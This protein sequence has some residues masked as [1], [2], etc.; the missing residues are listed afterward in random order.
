MAQDVCLLIPLSL[1]ERVTAADLVVEGK[2]TSQ[3]SFWDD[4]HHNIYTA[5]QVE[6]FKVFK[7]SPSSNTVEIV[8]EGGRV[9][10]DIHVYSATL[11]LK[12]QEQGVFFLKSPA[13]KA[14]KARYSV[15]GSMQGFIKYKL[16]QGTAKDPF[17]EYSS[18]PLQ[19]HG[20]LARIAGISLRTIKANPELENALKAKPT[21]Q[22][23]RRLIPAITT[24]SPTS[25]RAGVGDVLTINGT[26]FG[27]TR[28]NGYVEFRN[29]DD[30]G[31]TF[32]KPL[33]SD[34]VS[35]SDTQI[36]VKV[37]TYG[38]DGGTAG[39][40]VF[41]VVNNDPN[42]A[43]SAT[44]VTIV[45]AY[46]NVGYEDE[47]RNIPLQSYQPRL[48]SQ[49][50][51]G[52]YTFRFGASFESNTPALYAFKRA[53]NEWSCTTFVNWVAASNVPVAST[54]DDE[55]N[56]IRFA[57]NG[58]LPANVLGRTISRYEGCIIGGT[59]VNFWV[60]EIDMEY[61]PNFNWQFGPD[62]P[63]NQQFDFQ[64]VVV[65]ELGH[66][67]QLSHLILPRAVMHY[68]VGRG[69]SSRT[70][71]PT[72]DIAGGNYVIT[73]SLVPFACDVDLMEPKSPDACAIPIELI[74]LEGELL[75]DN[76][77]RLEW[78]TQN[79]PGIVEFIIERSP[80]G[81]A[82]TYTTIGTVPAKGSPSTY[83]F[84]DPNPYQN[85]NFYRLR[86][87]RSSN[88]SEY[89]EVAQVAG[90]GFRIQLA[91]NPGGNQTS[92]YY[93]AT[94]EEQVQLAIY[95]VT[96]RFYRSFSVPVTPESNRYD[97]TLFPSGSDEEEDEDKI[98]A[99]RG[100]FLI[101]WTSPSGNGVIRYLKLD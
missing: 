77:V 47:D 23:Q 92:F 43:T 53:M 9:G 84:I 45:F 94:Q 98:Y 33:P 57:N 76:R 7:G 73:R 68:A 24:F 21:T 40:G 72:N 16:P 36:R 58:E 55:I 91:P 99:N 12:S 15:F 60:S 19:V 97:I 100:L 54:A 28:G 46:S 18:I 49:N 11:Q 81:N 80:N 96:G 62:A 90:P 67:H 78:S 88:L 27:A 65:H 35:W 101:R 30:G 51:Q 86:V 32:I 6:I 2:V 50:G 26:N 59:T 3:R 8:T 93:N 70:L 42:T 71:N 69:Q 4:Q 37:P 82:S 95:D 29:A 34:Y 1:E 44:P 13:G 63:T 22:N 52:G 14:A 39:T 75:A 66:G 48:I 31:Q 56:A 64:S 17:A 41:R 38:E 61:A 83:E 89:S 5:H 79:E 85:L 20:S 25:L 10:M 74:E 87:V